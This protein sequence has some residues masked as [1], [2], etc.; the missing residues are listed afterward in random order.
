LLL[1]S[2]DFSSFSVFFCAT[3]FRRQRRRHFGGDHFTESL[4][5]GEQA[6]EAA[7]LSGERFPTLVGLNKASE[8]QR[9]NGGCVALCFIKC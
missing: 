9:S 3:V 2:L 6:R 8:R 4:H 7:T 1:L 5:T